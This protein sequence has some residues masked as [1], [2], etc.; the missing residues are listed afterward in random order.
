[1]TWMSVRCNHLGTRGTAQSV[2]IH[3]NTKGIQVCYQTR[4]KDASENIWVEQNV[5]K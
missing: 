1:M 5:G 3:D 2:D 4:K